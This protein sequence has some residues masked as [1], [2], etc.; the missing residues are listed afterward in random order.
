M[1]KLALIAILL[2]LFSDTYAHEYWLQPE[3]FLLAPREKISVHLYVG[4]GLTKD[5]EERKFQKDKTVS[6]QLFSGYETLDLK[7]LIEDDS[8]PIYSFSAEKEGGY[9][10]AMHRDW[11]YIELQP[12]EFE[13]YLREDGM[14]Y[15]IAERK[16]L[17]EQRKPG[18]ERYSRYIKMLLQ[19]GK[20]QDETYKKKTGLMLE[21]IP[22][23]NPYSK[24]VGDSLTF[25]VLFDGKP[26]SYK[27]VF[28][29][30]KETGK[31]KYQTDKNGIFR[32]QIKRSGFWLV[33][34]VFMRR[35]EKCEKADWESFWGAF[36]FGIS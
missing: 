2:L 25:Q 1:K 4:D 34:L 27:A 13:K 9:L 10:F 5:I 8:L 17:K 18:L 33:H 12:D 30:N 22:L 6:F 14:E 16:R 29:S 3:K 23:E 36:S 7:S 20:K 11:S 21:I 32:M 26:L 28:A 24:Q 31:M 19:V 35:C 15:I